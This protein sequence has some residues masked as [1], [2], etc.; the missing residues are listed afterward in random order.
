MSDDPHPK[1]QQQP[2]A[3]ARLE[4]WLCGES[5]RKIIVN[6]LGDSGLEVVL[7]VSSGKPD[8]IA[9]ERKTGF[10][11]SVIAKSPGLAATIHAALDKA[12]EVEL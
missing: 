2:D 7:R 4:A 5:G 6:D 3:L 8:V 11:N 12:A 9:S 10:A 1:Y